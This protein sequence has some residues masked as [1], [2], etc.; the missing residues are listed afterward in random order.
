MPLITKKPNQTIIESL[1]Y[2]KLVDFSSVV[3]KDIFFKYSVYIFTNTKY[4]SNLIT[5]SSSY[6][7]ISDWNIIVHIISIL[8]YL[9]AL[10]TNKL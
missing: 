6:R 7:Y 1:T 5:M 10:K 8:S 9:F 2:L 4:N 3:L